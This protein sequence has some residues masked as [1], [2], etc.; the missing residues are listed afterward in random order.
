VIFTASSDHDTMVTS[1]LLE[2]FTSAAD[3]DTDPAIASTDLGKPTPDAS[4]DITADESSFFSALSPGNYTVTLAAVGTGGR[5]RS[6]PVA[7]TRQ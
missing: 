1:Y 5:T 4:G 7:Y 2:V 3:T 6:V